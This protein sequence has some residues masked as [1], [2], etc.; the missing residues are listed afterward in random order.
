VYSRGHGGADR[1]IF[2]ETRRH[3]QRGAPVTVVTN[4]VSTLAI[5]L[6]RGVRRLGVREFWLRHIEG[7]AGEDHKSAGG[8]F[9]DI[10]RALLALDPLAHS[11]SREWSGGQTTR[12]HPGTDGG[13]AEAAT[14][15]TPSRPLSGTP[16]TETL[17]RKRERGR[18]RHERMVKRRARS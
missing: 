9:S 13:A 15:T 3:A 8:D 11:P 4:D 7:P 10:E 5:N 6:P 18:L 17:R 16:Q 1:R 12:A 14:A 2:D